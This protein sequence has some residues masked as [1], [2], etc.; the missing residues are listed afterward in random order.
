MRIPLLGMI[1]VV[2]ILSTM[3]GEAATPVWLCLACALWLDLEHRKTLRAAR[4]ADQNHYAAL[5][6]QLFEV[7]AANPK[8]TIHQFLAYRTF[9]YDQENDIKPI[10]G[11]PANG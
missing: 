9:L 3:Q 1:I 7:R 11:P 6:K 2:C 4:S 10:S 5:V 8:T